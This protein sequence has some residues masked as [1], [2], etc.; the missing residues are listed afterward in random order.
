LSDGEPPVLHKLIQRLK[1]LAM[2]NAVIATK[3]QVPS[4]AL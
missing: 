3:H 4:K 2:N 1:P